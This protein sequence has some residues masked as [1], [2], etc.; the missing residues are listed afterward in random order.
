MNNM[1]KNL[2]LLIMILSIFSFSNIKV[3]EAKSL[4]DYKKELADMKNKYAETENNKKMTQQEIAK[5]KS[6]ISTI[7]NNIDNLNKEIGEFN[8][9]I[10]RRTIEIKNMQDEINS[11][12][13]YYQI[14]SSGSFYLEYVFSATNY[15]DFIYRLAVTEQLSRYRKNKIDDYNAL[16]EENKRKIEEMSKKK[17]ELKELETQLYS[18]QSNLEVELRG[19]EIVGVSVQE[20]ITNLEKTISLYQ[21]TYKCSDTEDITACVNRYNSTKSKGSTYS[22]SYTVPSA[23]GF[24]APMASWS[25]IYEFKHHDNGMDLS[26]FGREGYEVH[27]IADGVVV[28][29]W[30]HYNCGGN[31]VWIAHSVNGR[32]YTSGYFHLKSINVSL[33]QQVTHNT[34]IGY[35]GGAKKG[36]STNTY[37]G[38]T[39]GPHLHLQVS[40]GLY[41]RTVYSSKLG[42][43]HISYS[44]W[45]SH[46]FDPRDIIDF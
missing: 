2:T 36:T 12:I 41:Y 28:D 10:E 22:A 34:I 6:E 1:K 19:I 3:V 27:P 46:S 9:D 14:V 29:I 13:H 15:T 5:V 11:I 24:Y 17:V 25:G 18:K 33:D 42:G 45:N 43:F 40:T 8:E 35:S 39:T 21:N 4:N 31:M 30:E 44:S 26:T 20:E 16:I 38:C 37:D 32:N 7:S 23:Y